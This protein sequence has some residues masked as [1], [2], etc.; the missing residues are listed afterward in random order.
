MPAAMSD[1]RVS[2]M[3]AAAGVESARRKPLPQGVLEHPLRSKFLDRTE[4]AI[5]ALTDPNPP[6]EKLPGT[7]VHPALWWAIRVGRYLGIACVLLV[8]VSAVMWIRSTLILADVGRS[9]CSTLAIADQP[10]AQAFWTE[11]DPGSSVPKLKTR[12]FVACMKAGEPF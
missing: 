4:R 7:E 3:L 6:P 12:Q 9:T 1:D 10:E 5:E 2:R 8:L 11:E